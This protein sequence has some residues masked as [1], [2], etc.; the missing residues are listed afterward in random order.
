MNIE[1]VV[2]DYLIAW[3]L[4]F[5]PSISEEVQN[6]KEKL[7]TNHQKEYNSMQ[8]ENVE[9]LKYTKDFIPDNDTLYNLVFESEIFKKIKRQTMKYHKQIL[10]IW[11][12]NSK[13][14][15]NHLKE[16]LRFKSENTYTVLIVNPNLDI[17]EFIK[18]NPKKNIAWGKGIDQDILKNLIQII[19]T[20][21]KYEIGDF[22]KENTEITTAILD[23]AINNEL[24]T[25]LS[26]STKYF[27]GYKKLRVLRRQLYPYWLMYLG[28]D[29]EEL[30]SHMMRDQIAF[31]IDKY[32]IERGLKTVDLYGFIDFCCK[33]QKYI[34]RLDN[35][36]V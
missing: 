18:A 16:I 12:K 8:K 5:K 25:R 34:I 17:V 20:C 35:L 1:F 19:Y 21:L 29:V 2:N 11:D 30:I 27:E 22:Q 24:Y 9:I 14:I 13:A 36:G 28:C 10:E 31:D 6:L 7:W 23:L 33:N 3:Y 26:D 15:S 32:T 4:L